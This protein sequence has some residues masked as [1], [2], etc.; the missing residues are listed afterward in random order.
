M[1][2]PKHKPTYPGARGETRGAD[3]HHR[4]RAEPRGHGLRLRGWRTRRRRT[5]R[6]T[7]SVARIGRSPASSPG[8][9]GGVWRKWRRCTAAAP[10]GRSGPRGVVRRSIWRPRSAA[11]DA[12]GARRSRCPHLGADGRR[13]KASRTRAGST[14]CGRAE[15]T[16]L[17]GPALARIGLEAAGGI[18]TRG[19]ATVDPVRLCLGFA[20]A[21]AARGAMLFERT[22]AITVAQSDG[23]VKIV[24][25]R[26]SVRCDTVI[27][28]TGEPADLFEPLV[29]H[30]SPCESYVVHTPPLPASV[31]AAV[32]DRTL[33]LQ[34]SHRP[35]HR[36]AWT[37]GDRILWTGGD[38]PRTPERLRQRTLVQ[39]TGQ[40]MYELSLVLPDISGIQPEYG[41]DAPYALGR[42]G[43]PLI[44]PHRNYPRHLFALGLG[45]ARPRLFSR[46]ACSCVTSRRPS[47][48]PTSRS[49][50]RGCRAD[51][52]GHA[53][54]RREARRALCP[55]VE[56][57]G[58]AALEPIGRRLCRTVLGPSNPSSVPAW[59][60]GVI[61][62]F[63]MRN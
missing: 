53:G 5:W 26:G 14:S 12:H 62:R 50:F 52:S 20:R 42:D 56:P 48:R 6:P 30:V 10:P 24:S 54:G 59:I 21:A 13:G 40:L 58:L 3:R 1:L 38:Q 25:A 60:Q 2:P 8:T 47:T 9:A 28:A 43:L 17:T 34:D 23:Y 7:T 61:R 44:G 22:R 19:D 11:E 55:R 15:G 27:V 49:D 45:P 41:W 36:L 51:P 63:G 39:R 32:R 35:P 37:A 4:R 18:R 46:A 57:A 33:I 16:W 31:R 29:R